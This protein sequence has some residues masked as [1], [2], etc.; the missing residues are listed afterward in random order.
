MQET[1]KLNVTA[2]EALREC[3]DIADT[4]AGFIETLLDHFNSENEQFLIYALVCHFQKIKRAIE[5]RMS[6][7]GMEMTEKLCQPGLFNNVTSLDH[8]FLEVIN[9][10]VAN[11]DDTDNTR[12]ILQ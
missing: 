1:N 10:Y 5:S 12:L 4:T 8:D 7:S 6:V 9:Q 11:K 2:K 3:R